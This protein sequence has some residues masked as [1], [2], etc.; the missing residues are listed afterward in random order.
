[1]KERK[2]N[3]CDALVRMSLAYFDLG[4]EDSLQKFDES[5]KALKQWVDVD[6]SDRYAT[7]ALKR[8]ERAGDRKSVV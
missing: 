8:D 4:T 5:L 2:N 6:A 3:L 7:L 1:M